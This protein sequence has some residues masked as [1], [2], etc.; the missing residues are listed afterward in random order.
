MGKEYRAGVSFA[1]NVAQLAVLEVGKSDVTVAFL[2][3]FKN[4]M[5]GELWYLESLLAREQKIIRKVSKVSIAFDNALLAL[6]G[7]P[8]DSSLVR[9]EMQG[10]VHWELS[11]VISGFSPKDFV[12]DTHI[13]KTHAQDQLAEVL[14][15]SAKRSSLAQ[16]R[17]MLE[18]EEYELLIADTNHFG[19]QYALLVNYPDVKT[20][21]VSL[22]WIGEKRIDIGV[23]SGGRLTAYRY[24]L[25]SSSAEGVAF[26]EEFLRDQEIGEHYLY[27]TGPLFDIQK[28][29]EIGTPTPVTRLNPFRRLTAAKSF[30]DFDMTAGLEHRF[31]AA[32]GVALRKQ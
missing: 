29:L 3:E 9:D 13:L 28:G 14:V 31:A 27:G 32:V 8:M 5:I 22:V 25:C 11:H 10:H 12:Q 16:I 26:I 2:E 18:K 24:A 17:S 6:H 21:N 15:V 20:R 1:D 23:L 4:G 7:F 19:A 30:K